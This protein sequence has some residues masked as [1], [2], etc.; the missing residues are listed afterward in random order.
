MRQT[1]KK[2]ESFG[3]KVLIN[4]SMALHSTF[5]TGGKADILCSCDNAEAALAAYF[6][7]LSGGIPFTVI[8]GGSNILV[9][10]KGYK[11]V[12]LKFFNDKFI[13]DCG[14]GYFLVSGGASSAWA[15]C[16]IIA[17]GYGGCEFAGAVP[18]S[19]GGHIA[20]NCGCYGSE[21][22]DIIT[23]VKAATEGGLQVYDNKQ[24][25]FGYRNSVFLKKQCII[26]SAM[27]KLKKEDVARARQNLKDLF[28]LRKNNLPQKPSA[29]SV[30]KRQG[31]NLDIMPAKLIDEAGLKGL[32]EG[33]AQVSAKHSGFI[34][35]NGNATS[36]DIYRLIN[37]VKNLIYQKYALTLSEEIIYIGDF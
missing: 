20:M 25:R 3:C 18:G 4:E 36:S 5:K 21:M 8:G 35:N 26:L 27:L 1:I 23:Y 33:G 34:I 7:L 30:F 14:G 15:V 13:K 12:I 17:A 9:S 16:K 6:Y 11:G 10:D 28:I 32:K 22:K 37:K 19:I 29:G 31:E 24:C 2:L